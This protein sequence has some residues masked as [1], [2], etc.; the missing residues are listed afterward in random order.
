MIVIRSRA[1]EGLVKDIFNN[2]HDFV[3]YPDHD[4]NALRISFKTNQIPDDIDELRTAYEFDRSIHVDSYKII[5][6]DFERQYN[7][8]V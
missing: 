6:C 8:E 4:I 3:N 5:D 2:F 7:L 1:F